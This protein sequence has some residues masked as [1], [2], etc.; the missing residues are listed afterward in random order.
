MNKLEHIKVT[1]EELISL[2]LYLK[3]EIPALH[4]VCK[5]YSTENVNS[6]IRI[7]YNEFAL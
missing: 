3:F 6:E 4:S 5:A 7:C 1:F 2:Q